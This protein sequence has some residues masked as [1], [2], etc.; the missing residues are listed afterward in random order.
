MRQRVFSALGI[1]TGPFAA[2]GAPFVLEIFTTFHLHTGEPILITPE[3]QLSEK[4]ILPSQQLNETVGFQC[5][6]HSN[7]TI[8]SHWS[9]FCSGNFHNFSPSYWG[10]HSYYPGGPFIRKG[11]S[12]SYKIEWDRGMIGFR[13]EDAG[14]D[15]NWMGKYRLSI[16][17]HHTIQQCNNHTHDCGIYYR[18]IPRKRCLV[19]L[20]HLKVR[21]RWT[22]ALHWQCNRLF[23]IFLSWL[24]RQ[25]RK[26]ARGV[27]V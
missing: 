8:W 6:G 12:P 19:P 16:G 3:G 2:T 13:T 26:W 24:T 10:A 18:P 23:F 27:E 7:W 9:P 1:Q 17:R 20:Q 22:K 25:K 5:L 21:R 4:G 15:W 11:N 14:A